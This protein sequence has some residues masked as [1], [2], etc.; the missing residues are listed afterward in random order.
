MNRKT[1]L[2]KL[3]ISECKRNIWLAVISFVSLFLVLPFFFTRLMVSLQNEYGVS[4]RDASGSALLPRDQKLFAL[5][6]ENAGI[7]IVLC[8]LA[9]IHGIIL[10]SFLSSR[11]KQD[12]YYGQPIKKKDLFW[13]TY[14]Q[15]VVYAIVPYM[16]CLIIV[17]IMALA[18][19][20][21]SK[22]FLGILIHIFFTN[23][24]TFLSVYS[25]VVVACCLTGKLVFS[26]LGAGVLLGYF[27]ALYLIAQYIFDGNLI[28]FGKGLVRICK[29]SPLA[30]VLTSF[31]RVSSYC[32]G[33]ATGRLK[34][35]SYKQTDILGLVAFFVVGVLVARILFV[36]RSG[37]AAGKP[38]VFNSAKKIIKGFLVALCTVGVTVLFVAIFH[39]DTRFC[40]IIGV[41][42]GIV[43]GIYV[44]DTLM[45]LNWKASLINWKMQW[46]YALIAIAAVASLYNYS[47]QFRYNGFSDIPK[48]Y[49][50]EQ[51]EKDGCVI[52]DCDEI[53]KG[54]DSIERFMSD[55]ENGKEGMIR[56]VEKGYGEIAYFDYVY[57]NGFITCY[58]KYNLFS[59]GEKYPYLKKV[60]GHFEGDE[61]KI[62]KT[63]YI[64]TDK[65]DLTFDDYRS[66]MEDTEGKIEYS[67][68][69]IFVKS[70]R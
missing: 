41:L 23:S 36:K 16:V 17:A 19:G 37:E 34:V 5:T 47:Y 52:I 2:R 40:K 56:V 6:Y 7:P 24:L 30:Y 49:T 21:C 69:C 33:I 60:K 26:V 8:F 55:V 46:V 58:N 53:I 11:R 61:E 62:D 35:V 59:D 3:Y 42:A 4:F 64:L 10:F 28:H 43:F 25:V 15:G 13:V 1:S 38:I 54:E 63:Y 31:K 9:I 39:D 66:W 68:N 12:F 45:E 18:N 32:Y 14:L 48:Y 27:P 51:A 50:I 29:M 70:E 65:K 57:K 22:V 44:V 20:C 67:V